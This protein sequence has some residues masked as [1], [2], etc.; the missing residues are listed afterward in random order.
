M[1]YMRVWAD[2]LAMKGRRDQ[3]NKINIIRAIKATR[4]RSLF[5]S[6]LLGLLGLVSHLPRQIS[7]AVR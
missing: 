2:G 4:W 3:K 6:A 7:E 5:F 1:E